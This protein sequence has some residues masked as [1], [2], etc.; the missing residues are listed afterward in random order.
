MRS[1]KP[2]PPGTGPAG[3][4]PEDLALWQAVT[5]TAKPLPG[6]RAGRPKTPDAEANQA[7]MSPAAEQRRGRPPP[8]HH[9]ARPP[10]PPPRPP[11]P[12]QPDPRLVQKVARG[13]VPVQATID[14]HGFR[15]QEAEQ[16][17]Y[18]FLK[19]CQ[20]RGQ[21]LVLVIT[22]KGRTADPGP[23]I[24]DQQPGVLKRAVP[25]WLAQPRFAVM[26]VGFR[27][28]AR[29]HG[30]E[31]ALYVQLKRSARVKAAD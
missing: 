25:L 19:R 21:R 16:R 12:G 29:Q 24:A 9:A 23:L 5:Q 17:L 7:S 2:V 18:D 8:A 26:V 11:Q 27:E 6:R 13:R 4:T 14:L 28:A 20:Q 31:G 1:K 15:Q 10:Q 3:L 30:G 22:G